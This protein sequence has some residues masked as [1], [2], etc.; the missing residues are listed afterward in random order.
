M[1]KIKQV[2]QWLLTDNSNN[3]NN[4]SDNNNDNNNNNKN[5]KKIMINKIVNNSG[6]ENLYSWMNKL[7]FKMLNDEEL[8]TLTW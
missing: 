3:G 6:N 5:N 8:R 1:M 2:I 4:N 7:N